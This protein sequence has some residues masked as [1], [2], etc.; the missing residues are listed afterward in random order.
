[1]DH[2]V[3]NSCTAIY[4]QHGDV[5]WREF[6]GS[7]DAKCLVLVIAG[8]DCLVRHAETDPAAPSELD[9]RP[10]DLCKCAL[11]LCR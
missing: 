10:G 3:V 2:R 1:M 4:L 6:R 7:P 11:Q 5:G 9:S 8:G